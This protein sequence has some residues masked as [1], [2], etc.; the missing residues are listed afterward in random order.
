MQNYKIGDVIRKKRESLNVSQEELCYG[1]CA[2]S[3][4]SKIET[5]ISVPKKITLDKLMDKLGIKTEHYYDMI[6]DDDFVLEDLKYKII[7]ANVNYEFEKANKL[8]E[9]FEKLPQASEAFNRQFFLRSKTL[10]DKSLTQKDIAKMLYE[11]IKL[12]TP[13]FDEN[14]I[15]KCLLSI[16]DVKVLVNIA[17]VYSKEKLYSKAI[18]IFE[19]LFKYTESHFIDTEEKAV[20]L[21]LITYNYSRV[22]SL[23]EKYDKAIEIAD[24]GIDCCKKYNRTKFYGEILANKAYSLCKKGCTPQGRIAYQKSALIFFCFD[25]VEKFNTIIRVAKE[26][27]DLEI[28]VI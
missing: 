11:A 20:I 2:T 17:N 9:D 10:S 4:L 7:S 27:F 5:G 16:E 15:G 6:S 26:R 24:I 12:T 19:Q 14:N 21:I 22:L 28:E 23:E 18:N 1:I 8:L 25:E 3:T 13:Q